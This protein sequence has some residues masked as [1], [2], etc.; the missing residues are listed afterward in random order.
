MGILSKLKMKKEKDNYKNLLINSTYDIIIFII[1][2]L[3]IFV[4]AR[5]ILRTALNL[6]SVPSMIQTYKEAVS[7]TISNTVYIASVSI[8]ISLGNLFIFMGTIISS[9]KRKLLNKD[10]YQ[11]YTRFITIAILLL[12]TISGIALIIMSYNSLICIG[13]LCNITDLS[14]YTY[15]LET[16]N[17]L[18]LG[19]VLNYSIWTFMTI[20]ICGWT[21][22]YLYN[23]KIIIKETNQS[24]RLINR[25]FKKRKNK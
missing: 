3:I 24:E 2:F 25:I 6:E 20:L 13:K 5:M 17:R 4:L 7:Y 15:E 21:I 22:K 23:K 11:Q 10:N 19:L 16:Y 8:L 12:T 1:I 14:F 9:F 18:H